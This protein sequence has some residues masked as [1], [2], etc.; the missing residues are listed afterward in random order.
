VRVP[1]EEFDQE[2]AGI[3]RRANDADFHT[4]KRTDI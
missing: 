1:E 2:F 4:R 3:T